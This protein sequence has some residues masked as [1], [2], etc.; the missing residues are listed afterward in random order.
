[1]QLPLR[2]PAHGMMGSGGTISETLSTGSP[3]MWSGPILYAADR[4]IGGPVLAVIH[5][6]DQLQTLD[7]AGFLPYTTV[8]RALSKPSSLA[9][10]ALSKAG[11]TTYGALKC[12]FAA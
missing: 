3:S 6:F 7:A 9:R 4:G 12:C 11:E 2:R 8:R 1:M 10:R 5:F